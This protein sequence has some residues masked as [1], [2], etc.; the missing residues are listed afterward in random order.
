MKGR[1]TLTRPYGDGADYIEIQIEDSSSG[2]LFLSAQIGYA[3][4]AK[5]LTGLGYMPCEFQLRGIENVGKTTERK[6]L[7]VY[8]PLGDHASRQ[9]RAEAAVAE[10]EK[11]GWTGR[12]SN[13]MNQ[14][15]RVSGDDEGAWYKVTFLRYI[16]ED[17]GE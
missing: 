13:A 8:V 17:G 5:L 15:K 12:I 2:I 16:D 10:F 3:D 7:D 6:T 9:Q 1:I 4:F 14:H 11:N